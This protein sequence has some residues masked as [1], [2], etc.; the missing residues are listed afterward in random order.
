MLPSSAEVAQLLRPAP[1]ES[2]RLRPPPARRAHCDAR[3]AGARRRRLSISA[4]SVSTALEI[5]VAA[6]ERARIDHQERLAD[7]R[8]VAVVDEERVGLE[9]D[10]GAGERGDEQLRRRAPASRPSRRPSA[11]STRSSAGLRI[12]GRLAVAS[13]AQP[14]GIGVPSLAATITLPRADLGQREVDH[15]RRARRARGNTAAI[16]LV[17]KIGC[18]PPA[19]GIADGELPNASPT[20]P[21]RGD[22]SQ[23]LGGDAEMVAVGDAGEARRLNRARAR[24]PRSTANAQA[25]NARPAARVDQHRAA[26]LAATTTGIAAPSARPLRRCVAYCGI[27]DTPCDASPCASARP[28]PRGRLPPS[29]DSRPARVERARRD[30]GELGQRVARHRGRHATLAAATSAAATFS[31]IIV[32]TRTFDS[33]VTP[34][35]CGVRTRLGQPASG[36]PA[37]SGS[38]VEHVERRAAEVPGR[39]APRRPRPRRRRRRAPC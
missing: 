15:Q 2:R 26:A 12:G 32:D 37:G 1:P 31:A 27:R 4:I 7:A 36:E 39:A 16:G 38:A 20:I 11:A 29:R 34:A 25:G 33:R 19:A 13:S 21:R 28:A 5:D 24:S 8:P 14:S 35:M 18:L 10:R 9:A 6:G 22:R 3:R 30:S 17:P 23:V